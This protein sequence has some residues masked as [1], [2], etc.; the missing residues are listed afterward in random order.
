[1]DYA[2]PFNRIRIASRFSPVYTDM[3][4]MDRP[5]RQKNSEA[6]HEAI[7]GLRCIPF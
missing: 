5:A 7:C 1:M 6:F 4:I 3:D 2:S